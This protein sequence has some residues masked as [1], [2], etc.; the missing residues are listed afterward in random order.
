MK[1]IPDKVFLDSN[2]LIYAYSSD[3]SKK[4]ECVEKLLNEHRVIIISTQTI[5]EFINVM[6]KKKKMT[7][8]QVSLVLTEILINFSVEIIDKVIIQKAL[9]IAEKHHYSYFDSLMIASAVVSD[10]S[11]LY[12]E[13]MHN[14]HVIEGNLRIVDPFK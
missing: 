14:Q 13:D 7:Y 11:I 8:Q 2:V 9:E 3:D 12:T 6:T 1:Q 5:N 4:R 10:C